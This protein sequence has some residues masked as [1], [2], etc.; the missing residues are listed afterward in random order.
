L[1]F[2]YHHS[3]SEGWKSVAEAIMVAGFVITAAHPIKAEMSVA[4][5]KRQAKEPIDLDV[6]LVCRKRIARAS[7]AL[8]PEKH[9]SVVN[10]AFP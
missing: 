10:G 9:R 7:P 4:M 1:A 2:T 6:I 3:R 5:P 8:A